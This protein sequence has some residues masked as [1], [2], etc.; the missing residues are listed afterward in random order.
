MPF[1]PTHL[2][3][4]IS[5]PTYRDNNSA[6]RARHTHLE[7]LERILTCKVFSRCYPFH[8]IVLYQTIVLSFRVYLRVRITT[9]KR[10]ER[11][12]IE[13]EDSLKASHITTSTPVGKTIVRNACTLASLLLLRHNTTYRFFYC[14]RFVTMLNHHNVL[15]SIVAYPVLY[16]R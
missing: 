10:S 16:S 8:L 13:I 1:S 7:V 2:T 6:P 9:C 11:K 15:L 5:A 12:P 14:M 4:V 3:L